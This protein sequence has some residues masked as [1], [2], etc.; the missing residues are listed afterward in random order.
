[1]VLSS[2]S[3]GI[4]ADMNQNRREAERI[5]VAKQ[6]RKHKFK[7]LLFLGLVAISYVLVMIAVTWVVRVERA[8]AGVLMLRGQ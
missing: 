4:N 1:M 7:I 8:L 5:C 3:S 2:C 6:F